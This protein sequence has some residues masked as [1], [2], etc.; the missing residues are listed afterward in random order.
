MIFAGLTPILISLVLIYSY[1]SQK[2]RLLITK[3]VSLSLAVVATYLVSESTV[4]TNKVIPKML[5]GWE[6][7]R[8]L[9]MNKVF[10]QEI[11]RKN[12]TMFFRYG[13]GGDDRLANFW[14]TAFSDPIEPLKGWNYTIDPT[15]DANQLCEV[16]AYYPEV[17][18]VTSDLMLEEQLNLNCPNE[19]FNIKLVPPII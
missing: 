2:N 6:N 7:P 15:G 16:N 11:D 1:P 10:E 19:V 5:R 8:A 3:I 9:T 13:Y 18:V 12:P 14:L 17:N 4:S